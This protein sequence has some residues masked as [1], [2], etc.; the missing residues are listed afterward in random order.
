V[1]ASVNST[2]PEFAM[3]EAEIYHDIAVDYFSKFMVACCSDGRVILN[4]IGENNEP[5]RINTLKGHD[6]AVWQ[7]SWAHP[8]FGA[9]FATGSYDGKMIVWKQETTPGDFRPAYTHNFNS[10]VNSVQFCPVECGAS[11]LACATSDGYV[12]ILQKGEGNDWSVESRFKAHPVGV[13]AVSW[14][15]IV[16]SSSLLSPSVPPSA[17]RRIATAGADDVA[18]IWRYNGHQWDCESR[19]EGHTGWVHD[20]A[21]AP[22]VGMPGTVLATASQ[23]KTVNIWTWADA[24]RTYNKVTL[25]FDEPVWKVSWSET[26]TV[27]AVSSGEAT[28]SLWKEAL[29][30]QWTC[31]KE[32]KQEVEGAAPAPS[33]VPATSSPAPSS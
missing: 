6:G 10:S 9:M 33:P 1:T 7:A 18:C 8:H 12:T 32:M 26:G 23:D 28:V 25:R 19:L 5:K 4:Q 13:N 15:P 11:L 29:D 27:L 21:F 20:V 14:A 30:G 2:F 3:A 17:S 16:A 24:S 22:S 31:L